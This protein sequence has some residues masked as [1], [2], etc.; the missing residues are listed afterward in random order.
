MTPKSKWTKHIPTI[1]NDSGMMDLSE[2]IS[3]SA[4]RDAYDKYIVG[5][6][7]EDHLFVPFAAWIDETGLTQNQRHPCQ[8]FLINCILAKREC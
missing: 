7:S 2:S 8:P 6:Q 3:G 5:T 4:Y 1:D